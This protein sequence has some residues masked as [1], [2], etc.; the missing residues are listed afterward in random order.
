MEENKV[1]SVACHWSPHFKFDKPVTSSQML[2]AAR[3]PRTRNMQDQNVADLISS[4]PCLVN[5]CT[6]TQ[7][8]DH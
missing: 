2:T 8:E 3:T 1:D 6:C 5:V 7:G 4:S